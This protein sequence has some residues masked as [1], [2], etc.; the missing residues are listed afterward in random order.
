MRQTGPLWPLLIL[1][2]ATSSVVAAC[3]SEETKAITFNL[4]IENRSLEQEDRV[5][6]AEQGDAV[7]ISLTSD[8]NLKFHLHGYDIEREVGPGAPASLEFIANATGGFPFT[9]HI[10]PGIDA[11]DDGHGDNEKDDHNGD[12][13]G[14]ADDGH[15][16][17][18]KGDHDGDS[19]GGDGHAEG[20]EEEVELGRL[21]VRP[22]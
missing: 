20:A 10:S 22:R 6:R 3:G 18:K 17:K 1:F 13:H 12:G 7:T 16:D 11:D 2:L 15:G 8:E 21:E 9:I 5:L 19:N 14:D 4:D